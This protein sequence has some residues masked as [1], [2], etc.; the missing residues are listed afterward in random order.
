MKRD[1]NGENVIEVCTFLSFLKTFQSPKQVFP[2][3][4]SGSG[5]VLREV[6]ANPIA[7]V[8]PSPKQHNTRRLSVADVDGSGIADTGDNRGL[9]R[10]LDLKTL[11]ELF[12]QPR[13]RKG[14]RRFS[15]GS[16]TDHDMHRRGSFC[17]KSILSQG[18]LFE[19][20]EHG[21][22][23]ACKKGLKPVSPNQDSFLVLRIEG[24][25]SM[26]GVFDGHGRLG[27][28]VSNFVKDILPKLIVQE[29][30][31]KQNDMRTALLNGFKKTQ[32]LLEIETNEKRLDASASG[33]TCTIAIHKND[34]LW[35]A[36]VGDSR[37]VIADSTMKVKQ[38]TRDHKPE[39]PDEMERITREGGV[40]IKP[41]MDINHRV[42][43]RGFRFPGLAMS[44]ALG[45]L[46]GY[47]RAGISA[48]PEVQ[49]FSLSG[50]EHLIVCSD[51]VWEFLSSQDAVDLIA[52]EIS[53]KDVHR[54]MEAAEKLCKVSWDKWIEEENGAVVDDITAIV[55]KL[56]KDWDI[57]AAGPG[58]STR[59]N[60][61]VASSPGSE[62][63]GIMTRS[64]RQSKA[65]KDKT[66]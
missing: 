66:D 63:V 5:S 52:N 55:A 8:P 32:E 2:P 27:H 37:C 61:S 31:F 18:H 51:G 29:E 9:I 12:P 7:I 16:H 26:Y 54:Q 14:G 64:R 58:L 36:N 62:D 35:V 1:Y 17:D 20:N 4:E 47:H 49:E 56:S 65:R 30:A 10:E 48:T 6:N 21:V 28:D 13:G 33:T 42:Y 41:P 59:M 38:A 40:V 25:L 43:V 50:D 34:R 19:S 11:I 44:R 45:D 23:F 46:I 53:D 24:Q 60:S 57:E 15:I 39:L 3:N 22:G